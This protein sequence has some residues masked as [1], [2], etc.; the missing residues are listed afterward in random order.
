VKTKYN[1]LGG[2]SKGKPLTQA[3]HKKTT[4][5]PERMEHAS[6]LNNNLQPEAGR[7]KAAM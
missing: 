1:A 5:G 7:Q 3:E 2:V 4:T 6:A